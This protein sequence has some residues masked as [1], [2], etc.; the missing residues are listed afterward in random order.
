[1]LPQVKVFNPT[2]EP[3]SPSTTIAALPP[4]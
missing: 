1:M 2:Q 4:C 3:E